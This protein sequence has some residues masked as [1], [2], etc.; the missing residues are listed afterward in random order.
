MTEAA[1]YKSSQRSQGEKQ[2]PKPECHANAPPAVTAH[3][4][5]HYSFLYIYTVEA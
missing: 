1:E 5:N 3:A 2:Y 4:H